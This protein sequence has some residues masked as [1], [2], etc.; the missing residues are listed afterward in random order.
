M[1]NEKEKIEEE[2]ERNKKEIINL[3]VKGKGKY[4]W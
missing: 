2:E 4:R 1:E 3:I